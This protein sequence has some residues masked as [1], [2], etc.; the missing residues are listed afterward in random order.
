MFIE[1]TRRVSRASVNRIREAFLEFDRVVFKD[2]DVSAESAYTVVRD[3]RTY[4]LAFEDPSVPAQPSWGPE[5]EEW[6]P[7]EECGS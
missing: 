5:T 7:E 6:T 3:G 4:V 1:A 2:V